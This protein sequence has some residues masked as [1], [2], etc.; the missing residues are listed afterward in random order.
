[1]LKK[2]LESKIGQ[3]I[4]D[5]EFKEIRKMTADDIKFNFKSFGKKPS[6]NDARIIAE[7]CAIALKRCS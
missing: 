6:H 2:F 1:M 7:R 5:V 4:S 3:H